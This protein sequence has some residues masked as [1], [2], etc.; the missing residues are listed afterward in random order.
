VGA[1]V[2]NYRSIQSSFNDEQIPPAPLEYKEFIQELETVADKV[3]INEFS[4][5]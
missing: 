5:E 1:Y 2:K 4:L 3:N